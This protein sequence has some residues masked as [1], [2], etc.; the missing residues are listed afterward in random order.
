MKLPIKLESVTMSAEQ[1]EDICNKVTKIDI[2]MKNLDK[3][4]LELDKNRVQLKCEKHFLL[5]GFDTL[6]V[7]NNAMAGT[8]DIN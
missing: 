2:I 7:V 3:F 4:I 6:H 8:T 5:D 1:Y